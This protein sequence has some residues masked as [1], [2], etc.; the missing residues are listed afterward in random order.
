MTLRSTFGKGMIAPN[1][2]DIILGD[3]RSWTGDEP[4]AVIFCHGSGDLAE[5]PFKDQYKLLAGMAEF[6]TVY[7]GDLGGETWGNN[8]GVERV[9]AAVLALRAKWGQKG[10]IALVGMSMGHAVACAYALVY[11]G[12]VA[13]IAGV[14]P[15]IDIRN[16]YGFA[17]PGIDAAYERI[18][19]HRWA[20][21]AQ[22]ANSE[23]LDEFGN[24]IA[25]NY[26]KVPSLE[27]IE[28][29]G[30]QSVNGSTVTQISDW[31]ITGT[32]S[33][34]VQVA[35][36]GAVDQGIAIGINSLPPNTDFVYSVYVKQNVAGPIRLSV[37]GTAESVLAAPTG[38][39]NSS[40]YTGTDGSV[41]RLTLPFRTGNTGGNPSVYVL[42]SVNNTPR[43]FSVDAAILHPGTVAMDYFD[44]NT[45]SFNRGFMEDVDGPLHNPA[46]M[47]LRKQ[48]PHK[49]WCATADP[50]TP[51]E[52][53]EAYAAANP[54]VALVNLGAWGHTD[55]AVT[56]ATPEM[57]SW[58]SGYIA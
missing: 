23:R 6:A 46:Q 12:D 28:G 26:F 11:P 21:I 13:C 35:G 49:I 36:G 5:H 55:N 32:K 3:I 34:R 48:I 50:F 4:S 31:S 27:A 7:I 42:R 29:Q 22:S 41:T 16:A 58:V 33:V 39:Y 25:R 19:T 51:I 52:V 2:T 20:G 24:I 40:A 53:A 1:E 15:L 44:G 43:D 9:R 14:I 30:Y 8:V 17:G 18:Y 56:V 54:E 37:Q 47:K 38:F 57:I 45:P 10:R